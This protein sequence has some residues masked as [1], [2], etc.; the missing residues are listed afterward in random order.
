MLKYVLCGSMILLVAGA[1]SAQDA[2]PDI[3]KIPAVAAKAAEFAVEGW[4]VE[5][6]QTADLNADGVPDAVITLKDKDGERALIVALADGG[7]LKRVA[8][9][10]DLL[11]CVDC[12]GV[13][14]ASG[15]PTGVSI[16]KNVIVIDNTAGSNEVST[17]TF[18]F[19]F[20]QK[21]NAFVLIGYDYEDNDRGRGVTNTESMNYLT[22][23]RILSTSRI[24]RSGKEQKGVPKRTTFK[25]KTI[26]LDGFDAGKFEQ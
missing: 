5:E 20:D 7:K 1:A 9:T 10:A 4:R 21:A 2:K 25:I 24:L 11:L 17:S 13:F 23:V 16:Q 26:N 8:A 15:T 18:K 14:Y 12:G 6:T 3:S 19:R 22:G